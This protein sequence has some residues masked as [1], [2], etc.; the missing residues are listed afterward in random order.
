MGLD[1]PYLADRQA[2]LDRFERY[3]AGFPALPRNVRL[4]GLR[5]VG[6]TVLLHHYA[7]VAED[8]GWTVV[9]R[10]WSEHLQDEHA[11]ALAFVDDCRQAAEQASR[12]LAR[13]SAARAMLSQAL[14]LLG[15]ITVSLA[16]ITISLKTADRDR[17]SAPIEDQCFTALRSCCAGMTAAGRRGLVVLYDEA[18]VVQDSS[19]TGSYPLGTLLASVARA[20]RESVPF[21]LVLCGPP[22]LTE[23]LAR[24]RA[25]PSACSRP[26]SSSASG[27]R[28]MCSPSHGR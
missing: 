10:D 1:P 6:K 15:S 18:H 3:L 28:R 4:T 23:N 9:R 5:G 25:T 19:R 12:S 20:Q 8:L 17:G 2:N 21:M 13:R 11:F 22:T 7:R 16:G 27:G 24:A 14:D 26:S